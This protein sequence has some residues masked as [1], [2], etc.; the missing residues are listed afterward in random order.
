MEEGG[1]P[2]KRKSLEMTK[3]ITSSPF[4]SL[5]MIPGRMQFFSF[6]RRRQPGDGAAAQ[7][8]LPQDGTQLHLDVVNDDLIGQNCG[9][10]GNNEFRH[11]CLAIFK[12]MNT[13]CR[14]TYLTEEREINR[15]VSLEAFIIHLLSN[16]RGMVFINYTRE[17]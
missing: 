2:W 1:T 8:E 16:R 9:A 14:R 10:F 11:I 15:S 3:S 7:K 5:P 13:T 6:L 17:K 12:N 4:S